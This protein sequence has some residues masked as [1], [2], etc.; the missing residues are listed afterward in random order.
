M[1][2]IIVSAI[3]LSFLIVGCQ[4]ELKY[5][6]TSAI[7]PNIFPKT[8]EDIQALV[9]ACYY[10]LRG[11]WW[12][13]INTTSERG[14]MM[15]KELQT[16]VLRGGVGSDEGNVTAMNYNPQS[17]MVTFFYDF[18]HNSIST[19]T[20]N[21]EIVKN[22][23]ISITPEQK[24]KALAEMRTARGLLCY[25]LFDLYGPIVVAPVEALENPLK[26]QPLARMDY[27]DM[28]SFI[29][30]DLQ[31]GAQGL[32]SPDVAEYGRFSAG[33][34][35]M[36]LIR[37][38]LHEKQWDK[39]LAQ[40]D[41]II[42]WN[43]Y[44]ID[45]DYVGMWGVRAAQNSPEVIWAIPCD[46]EAT[47]ENQWQMMALPGNYPIQPGYGVIQSSWW[48][49]DSFEKN[50][51]RKTNMITSYTG[52]DGVE[53]NRQNPSTFLNYGPRPLKMDGDWDRTSELSEVDIIEYRYADVLLSK[54]EA[55]ANINHAPTQEAM[56][57]VN[58]I[59]NRANLDDLKL[60]D[61]ATLDK[62]IDMLLMERGHE[63]WCENGEY[64]ADLIRYN[65]LQD[66][67]RLIAGGQFVQD[68]KV[69]FPFSLQNII[70]GKGAFLQ[71]PGYN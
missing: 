46:Y 54:A 52:S 5:E 37:L 66:R 16:G 18:Y 59:R 19:M 53:Y 26:D 61:Y 62:F 43:Y 69:L 65:K 7:N 4:K 22:S 24:Q 55:I 20:K 36:L 64:R 33:L 8:A 63:F 70:E 17:D 3:L 21:I 32:P 51:V 11:A 56:D 14:L 58:T 6:D 39:V 38:Y 40:C 27:D 49:Y 47:S 50:D 68:Y 30:A 48:F 12:D 45:P 41:T 15:I 10:P 2:S 44:K 13:G 35:R 28:I 23:T 57:L 9:N 29:E 25:D 71:N 34:A 60:S 1:K 42:N 31:A 67:V